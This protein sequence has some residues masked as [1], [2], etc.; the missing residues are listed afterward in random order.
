MVPTV[1]EPLDVIGG[2]CSPMIVFIL[3][4]LIFRKMHRDKPPAA[5][6]YLATPA[7]YTRLHRLSG[8][9]LW[10]GIVLIPVCTAVTVMGI[11]NPSD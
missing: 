1:L 4:A 10:L 11:M 3:P 8:A 7:A 9:M 6:H 2:T 5:A